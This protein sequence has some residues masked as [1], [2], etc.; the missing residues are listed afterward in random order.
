VIAPV[1]LGGG[2]EA[3]VLPHSPRPAGIHLRIHA[4]S[5]WILARSA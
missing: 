5:K 4:A 3:G 2:R 1:R